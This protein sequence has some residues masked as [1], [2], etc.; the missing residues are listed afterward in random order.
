MDKWSPVQL[1]AGRRWLDWIRVGGRGRR[2]ALAAR[3]HTCSAR[4]VAALW[5]VSCRPSGLHVSP[6]RPPG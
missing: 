3:A 6:S 4:T 2:V 1:N 5:P